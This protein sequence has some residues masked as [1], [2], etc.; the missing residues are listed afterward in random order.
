VAHLDF[1]AITEHS[2]KA[3]EAAASRTRRPDPHSRDATLY[4]GQPR[5]LLGH[6]QWNRASITEIT[7]I[8]ALV[9]PTSTTHLRHYT[10]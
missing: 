4:L 10:S 7:A 6:D 1:L 3:A 8:E 5:E 2:H 9:L